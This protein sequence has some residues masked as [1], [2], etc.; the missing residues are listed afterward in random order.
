MD[1]FEIHDRGRPSDVEQVLA[2]A[3]VSGA[4][5]L[6]ATEVREPMLDGNAFAKPFPSLRCSRE[7]AKAVLELLV[8]GDAD[9]A[10]R[11]G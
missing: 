10:A 6:L 11:R 3:E 1:G 5:S 9:G 2:D 7:F 4:T 8:L